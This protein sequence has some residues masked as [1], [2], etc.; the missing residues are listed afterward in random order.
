MMYQSNTNIYICYI[1]SQDQYTPLIIAAQGGHDDVVKLLLMQNA[2]INHRN[3]VTV[4]L[5]LL[6][7]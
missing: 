5:S 4:F 1:I 7:W 3:K 2:N 6:T